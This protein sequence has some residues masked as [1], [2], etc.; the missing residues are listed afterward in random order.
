[1]LSAFKHFEQNIVNSVY[2]THTGI[3]R[4][5]KLFKESVMVSEQTSSKEF[6]IFSIVIVIVSKKF[7]IQK[8][9]SDV[10]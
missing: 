1:M 8:Q 5:Q 4:V 9:E 2:A 6:A 10:C 7:Y 3:G